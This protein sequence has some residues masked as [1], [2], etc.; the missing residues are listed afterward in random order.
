L[1][2]TALAALVT[3]LKAWDVE[4][5]LFKHEKIEKMLRKNQIPIFLMVSNC[6]FAVLLF[7]KRGYYGGA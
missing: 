1:E 7:C 6:L 5:R 4:W 2:S 3:K